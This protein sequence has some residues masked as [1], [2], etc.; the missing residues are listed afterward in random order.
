MIENTSFLTFAI[1]GLLLLMMA[2]SLFVVILQAARLRELRGENESLRRRFL[3]QEE[4]TLKLSMLQ[5]LKS[6]PT[7]R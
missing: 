7:R 3:M 6:L 1:F 4:E 2:A 5:F